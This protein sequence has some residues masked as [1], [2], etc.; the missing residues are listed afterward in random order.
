[1]AERIQ[2]WMR[3]QPVF[4]FYILA[5]IITWL[6]WVPQAAYSH[7]FFPFNSPLLYVFAGVGPLAAVLIVSRALY[8]K[9]DGE[10]VF[11]PLLRWRV[12]ILWY[13]V[14]VLGSVA[15]M[16]ASMG[17]K[18]EMGQGVERIM[19]SLTLLLTFLKY[20][21]AAI[22]EEVAWRGF[23]LPRLQSRYSALTSSLIIGILW[24]LWHLPLLFIKGTTMA[25]YPLI[26]YFL[27]VIAV[28]VLYTWLYNNS[29][30]SVLIVTI[31]H[32]V[33]NTVGPNAGVEQT[34]VVLTLATIIVIAFGPTHFSRRGVRITE[35]MRAD[36]LNH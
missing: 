28:A 21:F 30:G 25:T 18:G 9:K 2:T 34:E 23:A 11:K 27:G 4:A 13:M 36:I 17:L 33:S 5:F 10:E 7:G 26:P 24:A 1:M 31:F 29:K 12:G 8:G 19:P 16:L 22:P 6:G 15:I 32:A 35:N 20:L 3:R 14:V